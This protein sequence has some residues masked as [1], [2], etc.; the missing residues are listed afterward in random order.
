M[1]SG[2]TSRSQVFRD[3]ARLLDPGQRFASPLPAADEAT[4]RQRFQL[5]TAHYV[6]PSL[7]AI[8]AARQQL[9]ALPTAVRQA[10]EGLHQLNALRNCHWRRVLQETAQHLNAVGIAPIALKGAIALLPDQYPQAGARVLGDLDLAVEPEAM[11]AAIKALGE[12]GYRRPENLPP[13]FLQGHE[14]HHAPPLLHPSG[15]GYVEL[16][17]ALLSPLRVPPPA[18]PLSAV[19]ADASVLLWQDARLRVPSVRH[20]LIHNSLHQQIQNQAFKTDRHALRDLLE[21]AQLRQQA[22]A[23]AMSW[24]EALAHLDRWGMGDAL[25]LSLG[26]IRTLFGPEVPPGVEL[27]PAVLAAEQRFWRRLDDPR[28]DRRL[29]RRW[30][31]RVLAERLRRLPKRLVTPGWL[32]V[33]LHTLHW[34]WRRQRPASGRSNDG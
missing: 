30:Q 17:R 28:L 21:F 14:H 19:A 24:S 4:W 11:P 22:G 2:A 18:L 13:L 1:T 9:P 16:H 26:L 31:R 3:L 34:Q 33:K 6:A 15:D 25:R 27:T 23:D 29:Q 20:R 7:Y 8:L 32:G 10:L 5:A 12:V